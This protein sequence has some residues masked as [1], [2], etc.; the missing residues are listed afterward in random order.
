[1]T[2]EIY[3]LISMLFEF[4][5]DFLQRVLRFLWSWREFLNFKIEVTWIGKVSK[6]TCTKRLLSKRKL[7]NSMRLFRLLVTPGFHFLLNEVSPRKTVKGDTRFTWSFQTELAAVRGLGDRELTENEESQVRSLIGTR[8][9]YAST[10]RS[11]LSFSD[12]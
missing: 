12:K 9:W 5:V 11:D 8:Q 1:M 7:G 10:C 2:L 6:R 4:K 3:S